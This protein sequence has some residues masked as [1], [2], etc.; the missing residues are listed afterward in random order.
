MDMDAFL[1]HQRQYHSK[2]TTQYTIQYTVQIFSFLY[3][4]ATPYMQE[5]G[6]KCEIRV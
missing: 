4:Y 5:I 1:V 3:Y 2:D 6:Y